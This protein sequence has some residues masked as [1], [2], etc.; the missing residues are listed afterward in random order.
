M[1]GA[2]TRRDRAEGRGRYAAEE[3]P[4]RSELFSADEME[5]HGKRLGLE[6]VLAP[7]HAPDRLLAR[8]A[9]NERVLTEVCGLL[10]V[11]VTAERRITPA[12]EWLLDN[13]H[14]VEE[15][16]RTAKRHLPKGYSRELPRL[17]HA[18]H[19]ARPRV[20]HLASDAISHGDG[21]VDAESLSRFVAA[22]QTVKPL[23]LGELWA[24]PIMLR[25]ALI[26]NLRRVGARIAAGALDRNRAAAWADQMMD[27]ALRDPKSLILV[28]ADMARSNPPMVSPFVAEL[29]RRLQGQGAALALPLTWIEQRLSES[30][31]SI[32]QL[33]QSEAQEQAGDQV[34]IGNTIGSLRFL[35]AM[36][37][38]EFVETMSLVERKLRE[39]PDRTYGAMDFLTRD[40]YRHAI[41]EIAKR[42]P[43]Q[44]SEV[45]REAILLASSAGSA[46]PAAGERAAH[47]GYYLVGAGRPRLEE[48]VGARPSVSRALHRLAGRMPLAVYL[49]AIAIA[50]FAATAAL[51]AHARLGASPALL[52]GVGAVVLL[53]TS[54]A[55]VGM[56]NW[57]ATLFV[58]PHALPRMDFSQAIPPQCRTLVAVPTLLESAEGTAALVESLEVRFLANRDDHV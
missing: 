15:Q 11:A 49:G 36:D 7:G 31:L 16:I 14:L 5:R 10:A 30:G 52:I 54:Q 35:G 3:P 44:E 24:I 58:T 25:L 19:G 21:R 26:E 34:S 43:L 42:S 55:A 2:G 1:L 28:I 46:G 50:S 41:E 4:L 38:R 8:L 47:V 56:V 53:A 37:W 6:H 29:A 27:V 40:R 18:R 45:A 48:A 9:D 39:D 33:V 22:Y 13:F 51:L 12:A 57:L 17:A 20:Y 32:E 23:R